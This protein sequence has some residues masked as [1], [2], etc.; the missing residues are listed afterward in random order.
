MI[1]NRLSAILGERRMS[2][3]EFARG[4]DVAYSTAHSMW[5]GK[6]N[7]YDADILV[8]TCAFLGIQVGDLL[9]YKPH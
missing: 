1:E 9:V 2:I 6:T 3:A 4:A 7:R 8:K 5:S